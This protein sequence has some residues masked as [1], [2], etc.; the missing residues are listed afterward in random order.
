MDIAM[1]IH[2]RL[3]ETK[4]YMHIDLSV[5]DFDRVCLLR[6]HAEL[7]LAIDPETTFLAISCAILN[8]QAHHV[9]APLAVFKWR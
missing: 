8:D 4:T 1:S 3:I 9:A 6:L 7:E 2:D 5:L